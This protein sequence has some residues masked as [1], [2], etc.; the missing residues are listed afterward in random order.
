VTLTGVRVTLTEFRIEF[1]QRHPN[2]GL[3]G[4]DHNHIFVM[5]R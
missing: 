4:Q 2:S 1:G 5:R 3:K